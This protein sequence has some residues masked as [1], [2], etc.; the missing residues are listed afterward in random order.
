MS[1][2]VA[3]V[4]CNNFYASCERVFNPK[5]VGKPIVVLSNNDGMIIARSQ[6]AKDLGIA[7]GEPLFKIKDKILKHNVAVFSSNYAL[8]GDMSERVMTILENFSPEVEIYSIDEAFLN[9]KGFERYD[10]TKYGKQ[11]RDTIRQWIGLPVSVGI[12]ETKTLAKLANRLAKK[13]KK[14]DGVLNLYKSKFVEQ[15]LKATD[16]E[17][18]WGIGRQYSKLLK[19]LGINTAYE[20]SLAN[21]NWV[22]KKMTVMGLRTVMEL[23][24]TKCIELENTI[25]AKK[26]IVSSRSF[27]TLT[28]SYE[29][30]KEAVANYVTRAAEKLRNQKSAANVLSV[31]LRTNPFKT[32]LPQ[33]HN[34]VMI[35]LPLPTDST[36]ELLVYAHQG[37][38]QIFKE[39]YKYQKAGVM[40]TGIIPYDRAQY[41]MFDSVNRNKMKKITDLIDKIN[42]VYGRD[43]VFYASL[44]IKRTWQMKREMKSPHYTTNWKELPVV[45]AG[46]TIDT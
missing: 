41:A 35:E 26:A 30:V 15:A 39:N 13:S 20:L 5:L 10:L 14:A 23:R 16:V 34:G 17:D 22:K 4:D 29:D 37:L 9:L 44:G 18:V 31:F 45:N 3:L 24:G 21:D 6:E 2:P 40:L 43:T 7:M 25:P 33:Y 1:Y 12:A 28:D 8:Y 38:K 19:N 27:G 11:I 32:E 42:E 36:S 46:F